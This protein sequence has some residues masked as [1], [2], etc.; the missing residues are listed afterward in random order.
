MNILSELTNYIAEKTSLEAGENLY[1]NSLPDSPSNAVL[2]Q[3][4]PFE[5]IKRGYV[6]PSQ[7]DGACYIVA[8]TVRNESNTEAY[9]LGRLIYRWLYCDKDDMD[10][11]DG[12]IKVSDTLTVATNMLGEP[13]WEKTDENGRKYFTF[14]VRVFSHRII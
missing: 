10:E 8:I 9:E 12:L 3:L 13:V 7:I 11:A 6:V 14:K 4:I 5:D 2:L 1:Y